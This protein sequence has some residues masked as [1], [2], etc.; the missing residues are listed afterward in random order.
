MK[1]G[2]QSIGGT[3]YWFADSGAMATGW[4]QIGGTWYCYRFGRHAARL[5]GW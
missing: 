2:W 5:L 4:R 1:T 3:W